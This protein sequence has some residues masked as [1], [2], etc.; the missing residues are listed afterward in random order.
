M[1][2]PT[3]YRRGMER[4]R[5]RYD[6]VLFGA[7]GYTGRIVAQYLATHADPALRIALG[8]R[9][10]AAL[11]TVRVSLPSRAWH[12]GSVVADAT[13][14]AAIAALAADTRV[15]ISTVGPYAR[16]GG[17]LVAACA[18][19]GTHYVDLCGEVLFMRH[20][21][22]T[23]DTPARLSGATIVHACGFDSVPSDLSTRLLHD[24]ARAVEGARYAGL[25]ETVMTVLA[26]RGGFSGGTAA[27]AVEQFGVVQ[28]DPAAAAI[29]ADEW[30]LAPQTRPRMTAALQRARPA[31]RLDREYG[32]WTVPFFMAGVNVPVVRRSAALAG[33]G[34]RFRYDER[35][36][37]GSGAVGAMRAAGAFGALGA[38]AVALRSDVLRDRIAARLPQPGEG[39]TPQQRAGGFFRIATRTTT[40]RGTRLRADLDLSMD[41]GYGGAALML[42]EAALTLAAGGD[43]PAGVLTP[44]VALGAAYVERLRA[45][46]MHLSVTVTGS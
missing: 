34:L 35:L 18:A 5:R 45:A 14:E 11:S 25:G 32:R 44:S 23:W 40:V 26:A 8:G 10:L 33:Y 2:S 16:L 12:W 15:V 46:G 13:D 29:A 6:I 37:V 20:S 4:S 31:P 39:P 17:P 38:A 9:N 22:E 41:P 42:S 3:G 24:R 30:A 7:T 36:S 28:H 43:T 27:S 1:G 21:L 19:A